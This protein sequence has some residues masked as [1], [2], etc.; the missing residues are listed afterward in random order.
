MAGF[1]LQ[2]GHIPAHSLLPVQGQAGDCR[3]VGETMCGSVCR[4]AQ[5]GQDSPSCC[6]GVA[7]VFTLLWVQAALLTTLAWLPHWDWTSPW[8][9][10]VSSPIPA[11]PC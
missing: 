6:C 5:P 10:S 9:S 11:P 8:A 2:K 7:T 1:V 3:C 4:R